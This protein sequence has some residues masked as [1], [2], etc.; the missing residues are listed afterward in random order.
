MVE[1]I[2]VCV[3]LQWQWILENFPGA[4]VSLFYTSFVTVLL[5]TLKQF[6]T[7]EWACSD[8]SSDCAVSTPGRGFAFSGASFPNTYAALSF[9]FR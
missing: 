6:D 5:Q 1:Q 2:S 4:H 8:L 7:I 3:F 9:A